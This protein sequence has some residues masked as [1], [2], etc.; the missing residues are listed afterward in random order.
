MDD[1]TTKYANMNIFLAGHY[2]HF[3]Y[4]SDDEFSIHFDIIEIFLSY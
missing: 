4:I 3:F 2:W 1:E